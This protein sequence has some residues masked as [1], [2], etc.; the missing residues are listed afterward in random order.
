MPHLRRR[1]FEIWLCCSQTWCYLF[2]FFHV[3]SG[4]W[5]NGFLDLW[6]WVCRVC[7][8]QSFSLGVKETGL[9]RCLVVGLSCLLPP[10]LR[11]S[12]CLSF[13]TIRW[14]SSRLRPSSLLLQRFLRDSAHASEIWFSTGPVLLAFKVSGVVCSGLCS[15]D[16][17]FSKELA[18]SLIA[19]FSLLLFHLFRVLHQTH[20]QSLG[21]SS[22]FL[23]WNS[24]Q[25]TMAHQ[26][27]RV[28]SLYFLNLRKETYLY[29]VLHLYLI[30]RGL[31]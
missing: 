23:S 16:S 3:C 29:L 6:L 1:V 4:W 10:A 11:N 20:C 24:S 8:C 26:S 31:C 19:S 9:W 21:W 17:S 13:L 15:A 2:C 14:H 18:A 30:S 22:D 27:I 25:S 28:L 12:A 5:G 7:H